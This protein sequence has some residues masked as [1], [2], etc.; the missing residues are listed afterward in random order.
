MVS[1]FLWNTLDWDTST[2]IEIS[3]V[4]DRTGEI[5][6]VVGSL[7]PKMGFP[8]WA[9]IPNSKVWDFTDTRADPRIDTVSRESWKAINNIS[10]IGITLHL[11]DRWLGGFTF[12]S[13][14]PRRYSERQKRLLVGIGD[15]V[16]GAVERIRLKQESERSMQ[17][18]AVL[19]ERNRLARELHDSVSQALYG[20]VLSMKTAQVQMPESPRPD[21]RLVGLRVGTLASRPFRDACAHL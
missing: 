21:C 2:H 20:T 15:M 7:L 8:I 5:K 18:Y 13:C 11:G 14:R 16:L 1:L 9:T 6:L 19:E 17:T 4:I 10:F 3:S 12:H